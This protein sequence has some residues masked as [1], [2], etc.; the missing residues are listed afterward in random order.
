MSSGGRNFG[1]RRSYGG[2]GS[3]RG[4]GRSSSRGRGS[5]GR[6][7]STSTV[8]NNQTNE[9]KFAP[10]YPGK[11]Q[12]VTYETL[13][14]HIILQVQKTYKY[15]G[16]IADALRSMTTTT[17]AVAEPTRRTVTF[18]SNNINNPIMIENLKIE[19]QGYDLDYKEKYRAYNTRKEQFEDNLIKAYAL[20]FS[21][22]NK[23]MQNR[24]EEMTDFD[25]QI[26]ND[27]IKLLEVIKEK[28]Y[29]PARA[30]YEFV[31]LTEAFS[32]L[33][34]ETKQE[35][36][37][38]L[39][40]YT[41]R[42]KQTKDIL[43][44]TVG[45]KV[46]QEF[47]ERTQ[48]YKEAGTDATKQDAI[49]KK[50][51][52][53]WMAYVY[54]KN[55]DQRKYGT[56]MKNFRSQYSLGNNQYPDTITKAAD[57]LT[58]HQ[59][60]E[61]YAI[62]QKKRREQKRDRRN[63]NNGQ[64]EE[65]K[66]EDQTGSSFKQQGGE[67]ICYCCGK[68]GHL[69]TQ[70]PEKDNIPRSEWKAA[71]GVQLFNEEEGKTKVKTKNE[72]DQQESEETESSDAKPKKKQGWCQLQ[73]HAVPP[74]RCYAQDDD[75]EIIDIKKHGVILDTG[76][77][78]NS[79]ANE[80]LVA[81][82]YDTKDMIQMNTN[83]GSRLIKKKGKVPGI[84]DDPWFDSNSKANV[85]SFA[86]LSEQYKITCD[87]SKEQA[88]LVHTENGIIKIKKT[89]KGLYYGTFSDNYKKQLQDETKE[90]QELQMVMTLEGNKANYT[91]QQI[92]EARRART[93]YHNIGA[94]S[95]KNYK[96]IIQA[97]AIKNCPVTIEHI[98]RAED[99]FGPDISYLKGKT[100]RSSPKPVINDEID[101]PKE[102]YEKHQ[103]LT[104]HMDTMFINGIGFLTSVGH[105][106]YYR[107]CKP[108]DST[109]HNDY[110]KTLDKAFRV[111]N[112]AGF[113][114]KTIQ[115]DGEYKAM[116][117]KVSDE[118][119]VTMNYTNAQDHESRA[120]RNN[121]TIKEAF[122]TALHRT[123]YAVIPKIMIQE[124][125]ELVTERLN[126]FPAK[127]GIS[128]YYSPAVIMNRRPL[129]YTKHCQHSFGEYVQAG[130]QN[131]PTNTTIER[132]IDA[133]YMRPN[134]NQQGGHRVMNLNTGKI[135][136]RNKVITI[137][138][139]KI[140]KDKVEQMAF[141]QGI[142]QIK[143]TNKRGIQLPN[144][145]W[146]AGVDY[147]DYNNNDNEN[148]QEDDN[149]VEYQPPQTI[150]DIELQHDEDIDEKEIDDLLQDEEEQDAQLQEQQPTEDVN[151]NPTESEEEQQQDQQ[152]ED[153]QIDALLNN[154]EEEEQL[155]EPRRS[156][157]IREPREK[158]TYTSPGTG[159]STTA[160][161]YY[162]SIQDYRIEEAHNLFHTAEQVNEYDPEDAM[163]I[164]RLIG[165]INHHY[166]SGEQHSQQYILEKGLKK[167]GKRGEDATLKEVR[168]LHSRRCFQPTLVKNLTNNERKK[169]QRALLYLTQKRDKS[170]KG[171]MVYNGKPTREW[172]GREETAS[173]TASLESIILTAMIDAREG[174]DVMSADVPNAFVQ[175][176]L[177]IK[178]GEERIIMKIT[179]VLVDILVNDNPDVYGGYVVYERGQ[180]VLYV[181]VL[182][183][184]YGMLISAI[185]WYK[186]FREDLEET[187]FVFN[188]YDP[189]VA[190]RMVKGKQQTIR[191]HVDD[192]MSSHMDPQVNDD[193]EKWLN[194]KYGEFGEV[195]TTRGNEHDYLGMTFEYGNGEVKVHMIDYIESMLKEFPVKFKKKDK[196]LSLV[197]T[198]MFNE[199]K[200]KKLNEQEREVF[201]K[202]VAKGLFASKRARQDIQPLISVLCTRVK[203]PGRNDWN[204]LVRMMKFLNGTKDDKLT[205]SADQGLHNVEW[206]VDAS[207]AVHPD[208]KSHT[209]ASQVFRGGRGV[210]QSISAKQKLNTSSS[211]TAELV[212]VDQVLPLILWT[213]LFLEA[214]GY[215]VMTNKVYQ[216]NR[217]T[218]LLEKNGKMSSGKRTRALNI[219]YFMITDQVGR[220]NVQIEYCPTDNM[221]GDYMT[222]GL[223]GV[224]FSTFRRRIMGMKPT[225]TE[226]SL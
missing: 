119:D 169:A 116:M 13:K 86:R 217:S 8:N 34:V 97:N 115:C 149:E 211:T 214:Q 133:I 138:L 152:D 30:K 10:H 146:I 182:K 155:E 18:D 219:R 194:Q 162:Q 95:I 55:S 71:K 112:K 189:C 222:K 161:E 104:F 157:R 101:I 77:T 164:A 176:D 197:T 53:Q 186:K 41:K 88:F 105:P 191:F 72:E 44:Q 131:D 163:L 145:D 90:E 121:R 153:D 220:G 156:T 160:S 154:E 218:I 178:E 49:K 48:E 192:L 31:S 126:M 225:T 66:S 203:N 74:Q 27:P 144:I 92:E 79:M 68:K 47:A 181:E 12:K 223:Q 207:F 168:Q 184:I 172:L 213:P 139:T 22:C 28:M 73:R 87:T 51:F 113:R 76:S 35:K 129:D 122:R 140:V 199:D 84:K 9:M 96:A 69:S 67:I 111:Y 177:D 109:S 148:E 205:L 141:D 103:D 183:A 201:H 75:E 81:G 50:S 125:A 40:D 37:E 26:R 196:A 226:K 57:A 15:G 82:V 91:P 180:K 38:S 39:I 4:S 110:Y 89:K 23:V 11:P 14:D 6:Q 83:V 24:I 102:I 36:D 106:I 21:Y 46:L 204:K 61:A 198:E 216:D 107:M 208:Y 165:D 175:T 65:T 132:T 56:L 206:Y 142:T 127:H 188:P 98:K 59:W 85:F 195:K 174:R 130:Q 33:I 190:N 170:I 171:R 150:R 134:D 215:P 58:N 118:L 114:I 54:M 1:G 124:L 5:T 80:N 167:F 99:I 128:Q 212:G 143:F 63:A 7:R 32:R 193:F 185:L 16:D 108:I 117:E 62:D 224:K 221:L 19:Q 173:P 43:K 20:I 29:D 137:P 70:C 202:F 120:E 200:S 78:F 136:T 3:G 147:D 94:P 52:N 158:W 42:F 25:T 135:I 187:G 45:N 151:A 159:V 209:G 179:G 210:I 60:D 2:R 17:T 93:L 123:G 166:F 64:D 100:T